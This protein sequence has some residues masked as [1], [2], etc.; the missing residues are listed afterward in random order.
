MEDEKGQNAD[1]LNA[2]EHRLNLEIHA[3][4]GN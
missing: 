4:Q 2:L 3:K 1:A